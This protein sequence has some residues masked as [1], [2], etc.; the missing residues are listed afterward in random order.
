M[1][2][3]NQQWFSRVRGALC[4]H[5]SH[6]VVTPVGARLWLNIQLCTAVFAAYCCNTA[7]SCAQ[8]ITHRSSHVAYMLSASVSPL[9][10]A[11][12]RPQYRNVMQPRVQRRFSSC[13]MLWTSTTALPFCQTAAAVSLSG[14]SSEVAA[15]RNFL[16]ESICVRPSAS[17]ACLC[18]RQ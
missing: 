18:L 8:P 10:L 9:Q 4:R 17:T 12:A 7:F 11:A 3:S 5:H 15:S 13:P 16:P 1:Q 14:T 6:A 2:L